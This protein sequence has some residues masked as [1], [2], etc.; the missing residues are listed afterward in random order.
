MRIDRLVGDGA[1]T[2]WQYE[3]LAAC[4]VQDADRA[5]AVITPHSDRISIA[6]AL[7]QVLP[8]W[9][10]SAAER[11]APNGRVVSPMQSPEVTPW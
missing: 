6:P 1:T 8:R 11:L 10:L 3:G 9:L 7:T 4:T 2:I 5:T